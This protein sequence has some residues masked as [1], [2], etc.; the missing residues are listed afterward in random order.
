MKVQIGSGY[1]FEIEEDEASYR[2][3]AESL[4]Q[5]KNYI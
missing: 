4:T 3:G 1:K 5:A 2:V